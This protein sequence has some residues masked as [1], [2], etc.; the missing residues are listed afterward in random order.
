MVEEQQTEADAV[1]GS[2]AETAGET[3]D[4][5]VRTKL[6]ATNQSEGHKIVTFLFCMSTSSIELLAHFAARAQ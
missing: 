1:E 3:A 5:P 6:V 4:A 2:A